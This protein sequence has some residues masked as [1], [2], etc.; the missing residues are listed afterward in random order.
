MNRILRLLERVFIDIYKYIFLAE[1]T[2]LDFFPIGQVS[3]FGIKT[4]V[5]R[6][7][8]FYH[9]EILISAIVQFDDTHALKFNAPPNTE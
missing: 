3:K 7:Q 4:R 5:K 8:P 1:S 9:F 2:I 6:A